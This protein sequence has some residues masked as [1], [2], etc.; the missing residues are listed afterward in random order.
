VIGELL[1]SGIQATDTV[2]MQ[3]LIIGDKLWTLIEP[4]LLQCSRRIGVAADERGR[5]TV[6]TQ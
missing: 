3:A 1:I 5:R 4:T 6:R 2:G